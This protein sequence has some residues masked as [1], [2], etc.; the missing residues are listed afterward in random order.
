MR[1]GQSLLPVSDRTRGNSLKLHHGKLKLGIMKNFFTKGIV[2][3]WKRLP[4]EAAEL[5]SLKAF[6]RSVNVELSTW[7][8]VDL[9]E[10][11]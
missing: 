8:S 4:R 3:H 2:K 10:L 11:T 1:W 7:F 6:K 5:L 9:V